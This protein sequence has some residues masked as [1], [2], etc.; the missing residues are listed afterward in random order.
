M[1]HF[2][3]NEFPV[4]GD[5]MGVLVREKT[6]FHGSTNPKTERFMTAEEAAASDI[7]DGETVGRGLYLTS[8]EDA[9]NTYARR[10][11]RNATNKDG[12]EATLYE[13]KLD[14]LKLLDLRSQENIAEFAEKYRRHL[15]GI[16][17]GAGSQETDLWVTNSIIAA[18]Q[19]IEKGATLKNI[20]SLTGYAMS[21]VFTNFVEQIGY[22]GVVTLEG[23]EG[24][25]SDESGFIGNHDTYVL[26]DPTKVAIVSKKGL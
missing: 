14:N 16:L 17:T 1:K 6:L 19:E 3:E 4:E 8:S 13:A 21:G 26:F 20:H 23:G 12:L 10:R 11:V 18:L 25:A 9:A 2:A 24:D 7:T 22:D 15:V 5:G